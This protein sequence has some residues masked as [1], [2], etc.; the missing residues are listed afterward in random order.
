[1]V[2]AHFAKLPPPLARRNPDI[3]GPVCDMVMK[4]LEKNPDNRYQESIS[5]LNDLNRCQRLLKARGQTFDFSVSPSRRS[6]GL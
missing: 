2:Y 6:N 1:M 4:L 5:I 3:P